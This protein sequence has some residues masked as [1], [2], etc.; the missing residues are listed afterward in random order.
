MSLTK[1]QLDTLLE[2]AI[3]AAHAAGKIITSYQGDEVSYELKEGGT[4]IASK[5]V[6]QVD[7]EAEVAILQTLNPTIAECDL[8]LLTEE[9]T[10][11]QSRFKKDY[12]WCI[13]PL[14]GTLPFT[15]NE[16]GY[17]TSIALVS[18][19][20]HSVLGVVFD[21]RNNN[22]Y[23]AIKGHGA[24]KN[25]K[26]L[27]VIDSSAEVIVDNGPG[28]AVMQAI[29]TIDNS[30]SVF[31]KRPKPEQGGGCL[32]D[33]AASSIIHSEAGGVNSD[34]HG[35]PLNLNSKQSVFMNHC[36]V[37]FATGIEQKQLNLLLE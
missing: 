12:F 35:K 14:D 33:Y 17:A 3:N 28:G 25:H 6:T 16:S 4:S 30:P 7:A 24:Y 32:W 15:K 20:G 10:D 2:Q 36:G 26:P 18:R 19:E 22:L 27:F 34:F 8:G 1:S 29:S 21:P 23:T 37:I 5:I 9:S 31:F 13:D 11:D